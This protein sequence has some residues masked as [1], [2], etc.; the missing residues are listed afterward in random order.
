[1]KKYTYPAYLLLLLITSLSACK[2]NDPDYFGKTPTERSTEA[3]SKYQT[4]LTSAPNGWKAILYPNGGGVYLFS[5]KFGADNRVSMLSDIDEETSTTPN[6]SAYSLKQL[7]APSL[8]FDTYSYIHLLSD[9]DPNVLGGDSGIGYS[10][11]FE[12][13]FDKM[14]GDTITLIGNKKGS[15]LTLVKAKTTAEYTSFTTGTTAVFTTLN[16]VRTYFKRVTIGTTACELNIDK[17][18]KILSLSYLEGGTNLKTVSS[19]F[20]IDG[21]TNSIIL[22]TPLLID[23]TS[24]TSIGKIAGDTTSHTVSLTVNGSATQVK[25]AITPLKYDLTA[26]KA[27]HNNPANSNTY[28]ESN[29]GFTVDNVVDAFNLRSIF[30]EFVYRLYSFDQGTTYDRLG[31]FTDNGYSAG[32]PAVIAK[33]PASGTIVFTYF[34]SFNGA[35]LP[36]SAKPIVTATTNKFLDPNGFYVIQTGAKTYDLVNATN[37]RAWMS[38]Y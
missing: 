11:D 28:W 8:L 23:K 24:I 19:G 16:A 12:F 34:G 25:E 35:A 3:L 38:F 30:S 29:T 15:K 27:F 14:S 6:E 37:A 2:K 17:G 10:S 36:A 21:S 22:G 33:F 7:Q 26:A 5:I 20:Y 13:S 1:M 9:P 32:D 18:N 31:F 4:Q